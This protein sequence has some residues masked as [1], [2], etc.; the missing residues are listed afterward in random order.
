MFDSIKR[1]FTSE[2]AETEIPLTPEHAAAA[3]MV[4]AAL[5]DGIYADVEQTQIRDI[6]IS[7]FELSPED[8]AEILDEAESLAESAVDHYRFTQV[9][10]ELPKERRFAIMT[11]LWSVALADGERDAH[12]DALMRRLAPLL[13]LSDRERAE[14]RQAAAAAQR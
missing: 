7:S 9:V 6:L 11:H 14:A 12:E 2:P 1:L 4:E 3:L 10:K 13:A 8:A 5:S